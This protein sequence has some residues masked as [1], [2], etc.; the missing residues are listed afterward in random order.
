MRIWIDLANSP[1]VLFLRP[2]IAELERR[3]HEVLITSRYYAQ[4]V[5]L[6]DK[7]KLV[8]TPIGHHKGK[9]LLNS[10]RVT[11]SRI[12]GLVN[13]ARMQPP[14]DLA[15]SHNSYSQAMATALLRI[16]FVTL[17]DYEH[18]PL[19]HL[20]FRLARRVLVPEAFP[21]DFLAKFG[22]GRKG[23]K[24]HG[25]KEQV[26]LSDFSP[27]ADFLQDH[28]IPAERIVAVMRPPAPWAPYH[29]MENTVFD[30]VL[31]TLAAADETFIVFLPRVPAQAQA[32]SA[33]GHANL[34]VPPQAL[35]GPNL[36]YH[37]DLVISGGGTMN[38]EAAVLSTPVYTVFKG[39]PA[40]VDRY[41]IEHGRMVQVREAEDIEK[42]R[43]RKK[44]RKFGTMRQ[45]DRLDNQLTDLIL[46]AA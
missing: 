25:L 8:H 14:I 44:Q 11:V 18:Q 2:I 12:L 6:A 10:V 1:Q 31:A 23:I 36:L 45:A 28:G 20:C 42:I 19:N 16:P 5:A 7:Y 15:I 35:D 34:W 37:A 33:L 13:W 29:R 21:D 24:Y 9:N 3:G 4:T 17:M 32:A 41:L 46:E 39:K 27:R 40:A 30:Q 22:A 26:Y 38:R 43:I